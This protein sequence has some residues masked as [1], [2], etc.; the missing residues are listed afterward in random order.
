MQLGGNIGNT[1]V[2]LLSLT[3]F[4]FDS[5]EKYVSHDQQ[6]FRPSKGGKNFNVVIVFDTIK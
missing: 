4:V 3:P 6:H 5:H 2:G 1:I